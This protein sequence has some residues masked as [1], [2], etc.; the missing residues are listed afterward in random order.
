[1]EKMLGEISPQA[2][3]VWNFFISTGDAA[4]KEKDPG[5][6]LRKNL[7]GNLGDDIVSY[8]KAPRGSTPQELSSPPSLVLI[9]SPNAEKMA[10]SLKG[11]LA[12]VSPNAEPKEREFLGK[13]I[14]TVPLVRTPIGTSTAAKSLSYAASGGYMGISPDTAILE[15]YLRSAETPPKPLRELPG[16]TEAAQKVGG[17]ATGTFNYENQVERMRTVFQLLKAGAGKSTN[18]IGVLDPLTGSIPFAGP[19][20]TMRDWLDF[21][22]LPEFDKI[23]K[24]FH[25]TVSSGITTPDGITYKYFAPAPPKLKN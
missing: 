8:S 21:S 10:A 6:D 4:G 22:L 13:K 25:F 3:G 16:L 19:E 14:Y 2:V 1:M 5:F 17:Q 18:D 15:E 7:F 24:Y 23:S 20:K 11:L 12:I 9:G